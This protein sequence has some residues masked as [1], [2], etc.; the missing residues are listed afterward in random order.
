[1][2]VKYGEK[3]DGRAAEERV[4]VWR[5]G[6][7]TE[8]GEKLFYFPHL[9]INFVQLFSH[10]TASFPTTIIIQH[11][12][13]IM[14][15]VQLQPGATV[16]HSTA[17]SGGITVWLLQMTVKFIWYQNVLIFVYWLKLVILAL[18]T[19]TVLQLTGSSNSSQWTCAIINSKNCILLLTLLLIVVKTRRKKATFTLSFKYQHFFSNLFKHCFNRKMTSIRSFFI[20]ITVCL[21]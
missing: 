17:I 11:W 13:Q 19:G 16:L 10:E 18:E 9:V 2:Q 5:M 15:S 8:V 21:I 6:K 4:G 14:Q 20:I 3:N 12:L 7:K 1:M